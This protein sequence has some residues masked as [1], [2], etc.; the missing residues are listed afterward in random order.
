MLPGQVATSTDDVEMSGMNVD[1]TDTMD[2]MNSTPTRMNGNGRPLARSRSPSLAPGSAP[3]PLPPA[4]KKKMK[5]TH[6]KYMQMQSLIILYLQDKERT[7]GKGVD[8]D[9]L[10]DW[11]LE[12]KEPELENVD[13]LE[14]EKEL[15]GKVLRKLVKVSP[16]F[17]I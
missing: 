9:D 2:E 4:P 5:I 17:A 10:I 3:A 14:Y 11:Y 15:I 12:L 16:L 8:Q 13:D 7:T 6:D 1:Q